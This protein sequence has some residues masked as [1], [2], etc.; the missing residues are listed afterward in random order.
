VHALS[1]SPAAANNVSNELEAK[2]EG[3]SPSPFDAKPKMFKAAATTEQQD[4]N[5]DLSTLKALNIIAKTTPFTAMS[6]RVSPIGSTPT[7]V[8]SGNLSML[9]VGGDQFLHKP[10]FR[11][12][13][14]FTW[15][16]APL[17]LREGYGPGSGP[18]KYAVPDI[19]YLFTS[20]SGGDIL[21][22]SLFARKV[23]AFLF[24][25][26]AGDNEALLVQLVPRMNSVLMLAPYDYERMQDQILPKL[27][28]L[29]HPD[30]EL[31]VGVRRAKALPA[32]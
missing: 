9:G 25:L 29:I 16:A 26:I 4:Y 11:E 10:L 8:D 30:I 19:P 14:Y 23:T 3:K 28:T 22:D 7:L 32:A 20:K 6:Y 1:Y 24:S 13:Y 21:N 27:K 18:N 2:W 12:A 31:H 5:R 15:D 17:M